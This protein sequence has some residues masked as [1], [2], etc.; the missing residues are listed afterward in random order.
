ML[1]SIELFWRTA[2]YLSV[3]QLYLQDNVLLE[4]PLCESDFK[5][6]ILGHWGACPGINFIYAHLSYFAGHA[7]LPILPVLGTG[8][9]APAMLANLYLEGTLERHYPSCSHTLEGLQTFVKSFAWPDGFQ[10]EISAHI[11]AMVLAGGELGPGLS[12]AQGTALDNP[13]LIVACIIGDGE[14]ETGPAASALLGSRSLRSTEVGTVLPVINFNGFKMGS[15]SLLSLLSDSDLQAYFQG[16][17]YKTLVV[18]PSHSEMAKALL[19]VFEMLSNRKNNPD[20]PWPMIVLRTPKG[21]TGPR[22]IN[23]QPFEGT[24]AS[25]KPLLRKPSTSANEIP[26]VEAW[27]RSY[28]PEELFTPDG[29]PCP[30]V[31]KCLPV[32]SKRLGRQWDSFGPAQRKSLKFPVIKEIPRK[33]KT[34][35]TEIL[36]TFLGNL[37]NL[38]REYK[39]FRLFSPDELSSNRLSTILNH[40]SLCL[41][42]SKEV[43]NVTDHDDGRVMEILSEHVCQGWFHGYLQTG[44]HGL[45]TTYEA[46]ASVVSSMASQYC[47]FLKDS[48]TLPW[49]PPTSS[50]N[51]L[52]TSLGWHNCYTHQNPDFMGTLLT[53][54]LPFIRVYTPPDANCALACLLD[55]FVSTD[56]VNALVVSK[57]PLP[58]WLDGASADRHLKEGV[59]TLK[60]KGDTEVTDCDVVLV[61]VGDCST[62]ECLAAFELLRQHMPALKVRVVSVCEIT[63]IGNPVI[64][65]HAISNQHFQRIFTRSQ[66]V[67]FNFIGYP[68]TLKGILLDRPNPGRFRVVGYCEEGTSTAFDRLVRN[69]VS[70]FQLAALLA[71]M[72]AE[73]N[74]EVENALS[75]FLKTM[76]KELDNYR[77]YL[78]TYG[79]D[80]D[81]LGYPS[82]DWVLADNFDTNR[83]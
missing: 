33:N 41:P 1:T 74:P 76:E 6:T 7:G 67:L 49:R 58:I 64:Y 51:Y 19:T 32:E 14:L 70:R 17:G 79:V 80:P 62:A 2:N 25:H 37:F 53:R 3:A 72:G 69:G 77:N 73:Y 59:S 78:H 63:K 16:L 24:A 45:F 61:G 26:V 68:A 48:I 18:G 4:R 10:T 43:N 83:W 21:W 56:R 55:M 47:K 12:V 60:C 71:Q 11:P 35:T 15:A 8:H 36:A 38:N 5:P 22:E 81:N 50:L 40:T 39:N 44:R 54:P 23:G 9:A 82:Q 27:L 57:V 31:L 20:Q 13:D 28:R 46:F 29:A 52:L 34:S 65:P 75:D 30:E 42:I 66:S